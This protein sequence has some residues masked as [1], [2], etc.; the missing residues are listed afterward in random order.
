MLRFKVRWHSVFRG[1]RATCFPA[2]KIEMSTGS[3]LNL[4]GGYISIFAYVGVF[5]KSV[6]CTLMVDSHAA[7][8]ALGD[9]FIFY[10]N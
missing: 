3:H 8:Q 2:N 10:A 5:L 4:G 1:V 7:F 6:S 9:C